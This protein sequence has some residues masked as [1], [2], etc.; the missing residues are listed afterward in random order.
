MFL[1][2]VSGA[3]YPSISTSLLAADTWLLTARV[4]WKCSFGHRNTLHTPQ[5]R[6]RVTTQPAA[7]CVNLGFGFNIAV[8]DGKNIAAIAMQCIASSKKV[9]VEMDLNFTPYTQKIF[10]IL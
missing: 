8:C 10:W 9:E 6:L 2:Q 1:T 3:V 4:C 7:V 5:R